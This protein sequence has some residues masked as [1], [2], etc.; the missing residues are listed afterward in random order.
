MAHFLHQPLN[1]DRDQIRLVQI[2]PAENQSTVSCIVER[3]DMVEA[4]PYECL[5]YVWG[6]GYQ[7]NVV[8]LN[9]RTFK[10]GDNL[11]AFLDVASRGNICIE[12]DSEYKTGHLWIDQIC[13]DQHSTA[14]KSYQ[15]QRM[16]EIYQR[17]ERT[18]VWLG[19]ES[20]WASSAFHVIRDLAFEAKENIRSILGRE[21]EIAD[22]LFPAQDTSRADLHNLLHHRYWTRTWTVQEFWLSR[23]LLMAM[24]NEAIQWSILSRFWAVT[25]Q[26]AQHPCSQNRN[27]PLGRS[28][29]AGVYIDHKHATE[30]WKFFSAD[31]EHASTPSW[32]LHSALANYGGQHASD[33]RDIVYG[34]LGIVSPDDRIHVDY[35]QSAPEVFFTAMDAIHER[36]EVSTD[37]WLL[38][39][40]LGLRMRVDKLALYKYR[41]EH[42]PEDV[43]LLKEND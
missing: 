33:D 30:A 35:S 40:E 28:T 8:L 1:T 31:D 6:G 21:E 39:F 2:L 27:I 7:D 15:V 20:S 37:L 29:P 11:R 42:R 43:V 16:S 13:I 5:S 41:I 23:N 14:E 36:I 9:G 38:Y 32:S 3:F 10:V 22:R 19:P 26:I 25:Q 4:P 24:G 12:K 34:L 17:A 18:I